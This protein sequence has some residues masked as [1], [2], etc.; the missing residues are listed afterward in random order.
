MIAYRISHALSTT[1]H[2]AH[3]SLLTSHLSL[4][5]SHLSPLISVVVAVWLLD[6]RTDVGSGQHREDEGLQ[7]C[8]QQF[9][10]HHEQRQRY[11]SQDTY[12]G[13]R[14]AFSGIAEYKD[15]AYETQDYDVPGRDVGEKTQQ[16]REG[17]QENTEDFDGR[18]N[19]NFQN[20]GNARHPERVFPEMS[21]R[22]ERRNKE[23]QQRQHDGD[24]NVAGHVRAAGEEGY[25]ANQVEAEDKKECRQQV[26]HIFFVF[27][28]DVGFS[29]LVA[30]ERVKRLD[31]ILQT[32]WRFSV[33]LDGACGSRAEQQEENQH[34]QQHREYVAGD[35]EVVEA[36]DTATHDTAIVRCFGIQ[37]VTLPVNNG[38]VQRFGFAVDRRVFVGVVVY[39]YFTGS[40]CGVLNPHNV[41]VY[42]YVAVLRYFAVA[43]VVGMESAGGGNFPAV[44]GSV[45]DNREVDVG[46]S[47]EVD[48]I[49]V[50]DVV[51][52]IVA[53]A[54]LRFFAYGVSARA[55]C[56]FGVAF[57][58]V[59]SR[60]FCVWVRLRS[61]VMLFGLRLLRRFMTL[62]CKNARCQATDNQY[63][64]IFAGESHIHFEKS[65]FKSAAKVQYDFRL[66]KWGKLFSQKKW[67][68][69]GGRGC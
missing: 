32:F 36:G 11:R 45:E 30:D 25:L 33:V 19:E 24:G 16:Q 13:T 2:L 48:G 52:R 68:K 65:F 57:I 14:G 40:M 55:V 28:A 27:R 20:C 50:G 26:R 38:V 5:T 35:G 7:E 66:K 39:S 10:R 59:L 63:N 53:R 69:R 37:Q 61:I 41:T 21:F 64:R 60:H 31:E 67:G 46:I 18:E 51:H 44:F 12:R 49:G 56:A 47:P 17:L 23:G 62:L 15:Q 42:Q 43:V 29:Y 4:L 9:Q 34:R 54:E 8:Y 22:A 6:G 3:L 58:A 1:Y